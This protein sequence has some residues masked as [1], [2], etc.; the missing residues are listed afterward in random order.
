MKDHKV[1]K[2]RKIEVHTKTEAEKDSTAQETKSMVVKRKKE[3][4][5]NNMTDIR[6][7]DKII[8][9]VIDRAM[10]GDKATNRIPKASINKTIRNRNMVK[11]QNQTFT[12]KVIKIPTC[13]KKDKITSKSLDHEVGHLV[14]GKEVHTVQE[15]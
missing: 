9:N 1:H 14:Q 5:S 11:D 10:T 15:K 12:T 6:V 4:E 7:K 13:N 8:T 3:I 2:R